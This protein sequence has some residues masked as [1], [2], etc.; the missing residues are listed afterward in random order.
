MREEEIWTKAMVSRKRSRCKG[1]LLRFMPDYL[2]V[3]LTAECKEHSRTETEFNI[4]ITL[5]Q[6]T[7]VCASIYV[8]I[9]IHIHVC[10]YDFLGSSCVLQYRVLLTNI[11]QTV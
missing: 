3:V 8:Y 6:E 10:I 4:M 7:N 2:E 11:Y 1:P 5:R 9:H